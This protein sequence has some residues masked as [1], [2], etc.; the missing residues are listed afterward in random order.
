M[1]KIKF[2]IGDRAIWHDIPVIISDVWVEEKSRYPNENGIFYR[3]KSPWVETSAKQ[4]E[5]EVV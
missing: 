4:N 5:L 2:K 3:I 1:E